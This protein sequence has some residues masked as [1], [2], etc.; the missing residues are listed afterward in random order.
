M[1]DWDIVGK[2]L[3]K[4]DSLSKVTG[5]AKFTADIRCGRKDVLHAKA[6]YPPYGHARIKHLDTSWAEKLDGVFAVMTASDLPGTN[7]YGA[8]VLDKPVLAEEIVTYQGD[9][10]AIVAA[11]DVETAEKAISLIEVV[12]EPMKAWDDPREVLNEINLEMHDQHPDA[13][14][15]PVSD[16]CRLVKGQS[17]DAFAK[18]DIVIDNH[19]TT[20]MVDHA[21]LEPDICIAEP[22]PIQ[23]GLVLYSPQQAVH[24]TPKA[25]CEVFKLPQSKIRTVSMIVG[26]GFGGKEDS[27][28]DVSAI[29]GVLAL[30][31]QRTVSFELTRE[32]ILKTT[33][34]RHASHI[35]HRL[36]ASR[37]GK[38]L[39]IEVNAI[40]DKGAYT[41][42]DAIPTRITMYSGGAYHIPDASVTSQSVFTNHPYGC[43]F[44][45]LGAPQA[46]FA[47]ESQMDDLAAELR[48]DPIEL[49]LKNI[50]RHGDRTIFNQEMREERGMGLEECIQQVRK[51]IG[52]DQPH[53]DSRPTVKKGRG[54]ACFMYGIGTGF[55]SD[56]AH[57]F[58]QLKL[59]GSL[60]LGISQNELG[61]GLLV[62]MAQIAAQTLG[63]TPDLVAIEFSD[64]ASSP[65]GGATVAS[66]TTVLTGNAVVDACQKLRTRL[67]DHAAKLMNEQPGNLTV[68]KNLVQVRNRPKA[69][70]SLSEI[71]TSAFNS[72]ITLSTTGSWFPPQVT[73]SEINQN[74]KM[75]AYTFG[76]HG[77]EIEV[78]VETGVISVNRSVLAC[79][80]GKAINPATVEG[81]M[82]GG[83]AQALGWALM[84]E[85]FI[86]EGQMKDASYHD[87]LI[88]TTLDL[89]TTE[90]IIVEHP[91]ELGPYGAKGIGEPPIIGM[92]PAIRNAF[93]NAT[94]IR[95]YTIPMTPVR[96]LAAL[97]KD[98]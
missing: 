19:F 81:Q 5:D 4:P 92:A 54:I 37:E 82:E 98:S 51:T 57:C 96:V 38:L 78:D 14:N 75:H 90:T 40:I 62:A 18:A 88:P 21:Y 68:L 86:K 41:S 59:D 26:G 16:T 89:P 49:R 2:R 64:T 30:K 63:I 93:L 42:I 74:D 11:N 76:A 58:A 43:A 15:N 39:G 67:L 85:I 32:E 79:D 36:A 9:A 91:N 34:K 20:P 97:S 55:P 69:S 13:R 35:H 60:I 53:K 45:G 87:F 10:V 48:M 8:I 46:Y 7:R 73:P 66:R 1:K 83:A 50:L 28:L 77:V 24:D 56:G 71:I 47:I 61:Q 44:R 27:T 6:L 95:L 80:I 84:E 29:A 33:G 72:Q 17:T 12:Y 25:L 70:I 65:E 94:G 23:G 3:E 22:E 52:W 31:T